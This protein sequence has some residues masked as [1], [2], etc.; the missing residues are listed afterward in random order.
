MPRLSASLPIFLIPFLVGA[1]SGGAAATAAEN[2][3]SKDHPWTFNSAHLGKDVV[4]LPGVFSPFEAEMMMLPFMK[5]NA[6]LFS[7]KRVLEIGTGS[8]II[9]V[10]AGVLGAAKVVG[11]D[12]AENAV[13]SLEQNAKRFGLT[14]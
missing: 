7:G 2:P 4:V 13:K 11:T 14:Q 6:K 8:G 1:V 10:Y 12:I 9:S 5:E 3:S